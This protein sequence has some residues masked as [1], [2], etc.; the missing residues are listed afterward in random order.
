MKRY[1]QVSF[2]RERA[3]VYLRTLAKEQATINKRVRDQ[4]AHVEALGKKQ[5]VIMK[6]MHESKLNM[7][8]TKRT[9]GEKS[10]S[11][12]APNYIPPKVCTPTT[13]SRNL[14]TEA[15]ADDDMWD[16]IS[17]KDVL[18]SVEAAEKT[19]E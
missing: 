13:V 14:F 3:Q 11:S 19:N 5:A 2:E 17:D 6:E 12:I 10:F 4:A 8:T 16:D 1:G 15:K 7:S 9:T 18:A